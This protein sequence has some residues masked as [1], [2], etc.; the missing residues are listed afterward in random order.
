MV[1]L[2][3]QKSTL[4]GL[5]LVVVYSSMVIDII[6]IVKV[7]ED[8]NSTAKYAPAVVA[9]LVAS[10]LQTLWA[11]W[12]FMRSGKGAVFKASSV[13][14]AVVFFTLFHVGATAATTALRHKN[15]YCPATASNVG[16]C[17][18]VLRGTMG[19]GWSSVGLN[20]IYLGFLAA[21]VKKHGAWS[22]DL[23]NIPAIRAANA[24]MNEKSGH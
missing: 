7:H 16:D 20:L 17:R 3:G 8:Q 14:G 22:D 1:S 5:L 2:A 24:D 19:L 23:Y 4:M 10:I 15:A 21:L 18:G 9:M 6:Q 11:T 12:Y 13:A